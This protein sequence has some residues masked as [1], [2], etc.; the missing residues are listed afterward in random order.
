MQTTLRALALIAVASLLGCSSDSS[1]PPPASRTVVL[2]F[3]GMDPVL[4]ERWMA[5]GSLPNFAKLAQEGD[6]QRLPTSNPPLS[7]VAWASFATGQEPGEHGI[8]D[9]LHRTPGSYT[10]DFAI[11][12]VTPPET[13]ELFGYQ[14]PTADPTVSNRRVGRPFWLAL[15][16]AGWRTSVLRV[17]VTFPPD[18]I[19]RMLSG[20]GVP[21]LL[22]TQGTFTFYTT[23]YQPTS[24]ETGGRTIFLPNQP[25][26]IE[27][28]LEGPPDPFDA[29]APPLSVPLTI[30]RGAGRATITL[31][32]TRL[33]LQQGQWSD[34][35]K[36]RFPFAWTGVDA[37]VRLYL[38]S[39][40]EQLALYVSPLN[41]DPHSPPLPISSPPEYAGELA[42][43]IGNYH[44]LG[45]PE[46]TWSLN[47]E[48]L[49]DDAWLDM[50]AKV[51]AEREAMLKDTLARND[52]ELVVVVF[53]QTDR[54]SH[55]FWRGMDPEHP[56]YA[57]TNERGR[58]AIHWIY[59]EADR[60][61]GETRAALGPNDRLVVLSD[62]GF[63]NYRRSVHLNRVL[64]D[65]GYLTLKP[66]RKE[67][68]PLFAQVDLDHTRAY[69]LGLNGL[70]LNLKGRESQGIVAPE[71]APALKRELIERLS[72]LRDP[73]SGAPMIETI[74]D[75][76]IIYHGSHHA[77]APDLVVGYAA[78]YRASWQ[79][80]L[81][82]VPA[83]TVEDNRGKWSGDHA[84]SPELV[85]G[86]LFTSFPLEQPVPG[87][88]SLAQL[89]GTR[90]VA[91]VMA[92]HVQSH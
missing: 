18:P 33:E 82:G 68:G 90:A 50:V 26:T 22:G 54:V 84:V 86:V 55:M 73:E 79:T 11:A 5:D 47:Q 78:D 46:E 69:A 80:T 27:S 38:V 52:S 44:T 14:L 4:A 53:V 61:L 43:R 6:Y 24:S 36:V 42:D 1:A 10:P 30:E 77:D 9:F 13:I 15:E 29:K 57:E 67:S 62:H 70:Y 92:G 21:D 85:P 8:F 35:I 41:F 31:D 56:R 71:Q 60:I 59:Q 45:M 28:S 23:E 39:S 17:P 34:F 12:K 37:L 7:P 66:G 32:G 58:N 49:S 91:T 16:E 2:G 75:S 51:L 40:G 20:M 88:E 64:A 3:D 87:L 83:L 81:G 74:Y 89:I 76:D 25:G 65:A 19:H 63:N 72:G 48:K